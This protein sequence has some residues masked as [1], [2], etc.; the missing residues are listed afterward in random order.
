M[1]KDINQ[2]LLDSNGFAIFLERQ[3]FDLE[4]QIKHLGFEIK[5]APSKEFSKKNQAENKPKFSLNQEQK[6]FLMNTLARVIVE[7][8]MNFYRFEVNQ[9]LPVANYKKSQIMLSS[10]KNQ[11]I[12]KKPQLSFLIVS[13]PNNQTQ[14]FFQSIKQ[15]K[16]AFAEINPPENLV[17]W[18]NK[19]QALFK[20]IQ[21]LNQKAPKN[22]VE[23]PSLIF[24]QLLVLNTS[25]AISDL[26]TGFYLFILAIFAVF[27]KNSWLGGWAKTIFGID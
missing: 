13:F 16:I 26:G 10:Q 9:N 12:E 15:H 14:N 23:D 20:I 22:D 6:E 18:Q 8:R 25:L 4:K 27:W 11:E 19:P 5:K 3:K 24:W 21:R 2:V 17:F 7:R 1:K